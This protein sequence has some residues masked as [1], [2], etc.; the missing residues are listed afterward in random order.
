M[1]TTTTNLVLIKGRQ[2]VRVAVAHDGRE[3]QR[4]G[5]DVRDNSVTRCQQD[6]ESRH[7][8]G[9]Y[10]HTLAAAAAAAS[11]ALVSGLVISCLV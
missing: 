7:C 5:A 2:R 8:P 11:V 4:I 10:I 6:W 3:H 1:H 9:T